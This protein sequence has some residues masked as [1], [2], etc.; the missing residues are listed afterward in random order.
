MIK[1]LTILSMLVG[2]VV[3]GPAAVASVWGFF[4]NVE[5]TVTGRPAP[6]PA[7]SDLLTTASAP[8]PFPPKAAGAPQSVGATPVVTE[9]A[10]P[11][12]IDVA[13]AV[14]SPVVKIDEPCAFAWHGD[15]SVRKVSCPTD[16][17]CE[18]GPPSVREISVEYGAVAPRSAGA[19]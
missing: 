18:I 2:L 6:T 4:Q 16:W 5:S 19:G 15:G 17:S 12:A 14:G 11:N 8:T 10:C 7:A 3:E 13:A 9:P 1:A